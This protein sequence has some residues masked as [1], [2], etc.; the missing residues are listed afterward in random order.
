MS[1]LLGKKRG[2]C[3]ASRGIRSN[4]WP[5]TR[6][7]SS[8]QSKRIRR[9][10]WSILGV[11]A[12]LLL[13]AC[14]AAWY[15]SPRRQA[16]VYIL[17]MPEQPM[18]SFD[19]VSGEGS[20][21]F[22]PVHRAIP[23]RFAEKVLGHKRFERWLGFLCPIED[24]HITPKAHT[25]VADVMRRISYFPELR[26]LTIGTMDADRSLDAYPNLDEWEL[27][28]FLHLAD[29]KDLEFLRIQGVPITDV[30]LEYV[31]CLPR[32]NCLHLKYVNVKGDAFVKP[33]ASAATLEELWLNDM[34]FHVRNAAGLEQFEKLRLL[35]FLC[36]DLQYATESEARA[37]MEIMNRLKNERHVDTGM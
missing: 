16:L 27:D 14:V 13:I 36:C 20:H 18:V 34:S 9:M 29:L 3:T 1:T 17:S 8:D 35:D 26:S 11:L 23:T 15:Y 24:M 22:V 33:W 5:L 10:A 2:R 30:H 32:L 37:F 25:D 4:R 12:L 19:K 21:T 6:R 31:A 7:A 28:A